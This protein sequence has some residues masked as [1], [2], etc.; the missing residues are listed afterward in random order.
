MGGMALESLPHFLRALAYNG[1]FNSFISA[2][3]GDDRSRIEAMSTA[4][5]R[6]IKQPGICRQERIL[7]PLKGVNAAA[8]S[9]NRDAKTPA[10]SLFFA[11]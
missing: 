3:G 6:A 2:Q 7:S 10:T 5:G 11:G 1:G 9:A 8:A 4:L